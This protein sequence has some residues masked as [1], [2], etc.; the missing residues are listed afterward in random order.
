[1][2]KCF[3]MIL[4][5]LALAFSLYAAPGATA[6]KGKVTDAAT[7]Q[8]IAGAILSLDDGA[9]WAVADIDGNYSFPGLSP[10]SYLLKVECL[11]YVTRTANLSVKGGRTELSD[12][13][14]TP[15]SNILA[16]DAESLALK[17]VYVTAQRPAGTLGTSHTLGKDA[18][19]HLQMSS[20]TDMTALLPG[21]KTINPDLTQD[22]AFS[23]RNGGSTVGNAAFG[24]AL[25][26][27]GVRVG[28]NASLS[29]PG[30]AGTRSVAIENIESIEVITGVPSAEYGDLNAGMVKINTKKGRTPVNVTFSVNPRTYQV[31]AGKG[32][33][34]RKERGILNISA[35]WARSTQKL[36]SP[37]TSYTR[38]GFTAT[39]TNTWRKNLHF[40]AGGSVNI[41]GMDSKDDPDANAGNFEKGRD[42]AYR[43][44]TNLSWMLNKS[45]ITSLKLDASVSLSDNLSHTH[46]Y[47][48]SASTQPA[49][50]SETEGY[51]WADL[52]PLSYHSDKMVD[53][54]ELDA[55]ASLK[56][57]WTRSFGSVKNRLKAGVQFKTSGNVGQGEY[58]LDPALAPNGYRPRP[59]SQYPF[60]H[61]LSEYIEDHVTVPVW[62]TKLEAVAG[63]RFEQVFVKGSR[64]SSVGSLS[65]RFNV[66]W[67]LRK[68]LAVRAGWG[69][70]EKLPSFWVLFPKQEYLDILTDTKTAGTVSQYEYYTVPYAIEYNPDL[71][72]QRNQNSEIGVD[73][74]PGKWKISLVGFYNLTLNPYQYV[75]SY[76][77]LTYVN[78]RSGVTDMTFVRTTVQTNGKPVTRAGAELTVDFP[79]ISPIRTSFRLDATYN[80]TSYVDDL[81]AAY[82][83]SGLSH[84]TESGKSYPYFGVYAR[85]ASTS[86]VN[87]RRINNV[88][89]NITAITHIPEARLVI[90]CRLEM[91]IL[92]RS[93]NLSQYNGHEYAFNVYET[94]NQKKGG[95]IY[96]GGDFAAIW[97]LYYVDVDGIRHDFT[98]TQAVDNNYSNLVVK[99]G[100]AYTYSPDGYG[101]Y[102]SANLSITKEIGKHVSLSFFANNFADSRPAV[103]SFATGVSAVFTPAFYYGLTCR[104][105]I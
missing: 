77:P 36:I 7:G 57:D 4:A 65:P 33:D 1:M 55:A 32:I 51:A 48:S 49:I 47:A 79:E 74:T 89:A 31:S 88:D 86:T 21:G 91:A 96:D 60:M 94:S 103:T 13:S 26:V 99:T 53:S 78:H 41:G 14:G 97:P 44:H 101:F 8:P 71:K 50:H 85:G 40:E 3:L 16:L 54:K 38:R 2:H 93:R 29:E 24:T 35:E 68:D 69:V 83:P 105:K 46:A 70:S 58:Y 52:L 75:N 76:T 5:V 9:I 80:H 100:N 87:G 6:F 72:W 104:I 23:L 25:E 27:D 64:Y 42:N 63:L 73:Y 45:W 22:N 10:G 59:Y 67:T 61:N 102:C 15:L 28:N 92:R 37:Y 95:S 84:P 66:K 43:A 30:G 20:L 34:L 12:G 17:E 98:M 90:T 62:E 82:Y 39:Y 81:P 18:L 11:G 56:Y 19:E